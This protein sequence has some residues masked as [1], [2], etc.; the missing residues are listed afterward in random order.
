MAP[1]PAAPALDSFVIYARSLLYVQAFIWGLICVEAILLGTSTWSATPAN[2]PL[3]QLQHVP[4]LALGAAGVLAAAKA[5][6][7]RRISRRSSGTRQAVIVVECLMAC[8]GVGLCFLTANLDGG[9]LPFCAGFFGG[10]M[11]LVAAIG[12][13]RPPARQY[14]ATPS[15]KVTQMNATSR[16]GHGRS[17]PFWCI[18]RETPIF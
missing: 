15:S 18:T 5:W 11:S 2:S 4:A 3:H 9:L 1:M 14:F 8:V 16:P 12:L 17:T 7:G 13:T 10:N 6:L